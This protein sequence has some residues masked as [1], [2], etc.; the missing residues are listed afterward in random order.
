MTYRI[1]YGDELYHYGV[2]GMKWGVRKEQKYAEKEKKWA[3]KEASRKSNFGKNL[4]TTRKL[5]YRLA[6]E[7]QRA[8]NNATTLKSKLQNKV[9][10]EAD[11]RNNR[12]SSEL[13][14][15]RAKR[16]KNVKRKIRNESRAY[17]MTQAG[18][19]R[20]SV[21]SGTKSTIKRDI[22]FTKQIWNTPAKT[23]KGKNTTFGKEIVKATAAVAAYEVALSV[24][25]VYVKSKYGF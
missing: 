24:A 20:E 10:M 18:K 23:L 25:N 21:A 13:Y 22:R 11:A 15:T 6:K 7:N 17:N 14:S 2:K 12:I 9:G 19:V 16:T 3:S 5:G 8:A 4:A 1:V